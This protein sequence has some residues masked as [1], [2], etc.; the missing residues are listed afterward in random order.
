MY[1]SVYTTYISVYRRLS[2]CISGP[3]IVT[4]PLTVRRAAI[5]TT[6]GRGGCQQQRVG[7][8]GTH[9]TV[10]WITVPTRFASNTLLRA[11]LEA[12][13]S[14]QH[15]KKTEETRFFLIIRRQCQSCLS[16][17]RDASRTCF[18]ADF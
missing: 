12:Q 3:E 8:V 13:P 16:I 10:V 17:S 1:I 7:G 14:Q 15:K 11:V 2:L 9:Q 5:R 4:G 18:A 6:A